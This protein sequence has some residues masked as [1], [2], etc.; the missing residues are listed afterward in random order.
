MYIISTEAD[1]LWK[2]TG[3]FLNQTAG[4]P[5]LRRRRRREIFS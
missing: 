2:Q 1:I 3:L 4:E 5:E